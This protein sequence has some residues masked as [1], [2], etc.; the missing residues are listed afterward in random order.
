MIPTE[1]GV[2]WSDGG[3][4]ICS[5]HVLYEIIRIPLSR[6]QH[7][8][9]THRL[10]DTDSPALRERWTG[11]RTPFPSMSAA[12]PPR[13]CLP[14]AKASGLNRLVWTLDSRRAGVPWMP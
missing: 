11:H 14:Y 8:H 7:K 2:W 1:G 12:S 5:R 4:T 3:W 10:P 13:L 6:K 9:Y